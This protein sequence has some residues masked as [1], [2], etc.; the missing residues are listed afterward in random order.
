MKILICN[1]DG[2]W[3]KG[4]S[5][6]AKA[7]QNMG[8][9]TVV[10][11][12]VER[13]ATGHAITI[14]D[15]V[16]VRETTLWESDIKGYALTGTPADCVKFGVSMIMDEPPDIVVS[17][18]N[19][20]PNL[21]T[22]VLYSGTVSAA[23]EASIL[24]IPAMAVSLDSYDDEDYSFAAQAALEI[25]RKMTKR[26]LPANILLNVNVPD[27]PSHLCKGIKVTKL[28]IRK[29]K[30]NYIKRIDPR[31]GVYYWLA[32]D[33][34]EEEQLDDVDI[35][36]VKDGYISVTPIHYNLTA[37]S[38]LENVMDWFNDG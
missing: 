17:G 31:G 33:L 21:G 1:D 7:M 35:A 16:R 3:S 34:V 14:H 29:Y 38:Q 25:A 22:D 30:E 23:I 2:I 18:I 24:G 32:G 36:A 8:E 11:P 26:H 13:S 27:V 6:L 9:I 5:E 37:Y 20:G 15:P 10:A 12:D 28:G 19:R 4:I